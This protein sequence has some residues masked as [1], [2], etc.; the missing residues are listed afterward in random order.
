MSV[1]VVVVEVFE[2][3]DDEGVYPEDEEDGG[4]G[5]YLG[6]VVIFVEDDEVHEGVPEKEESPLV[7]ERLGE[8]V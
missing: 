1:F 4:L 2:V 5:C 7:G 8:G 3:V 6:G